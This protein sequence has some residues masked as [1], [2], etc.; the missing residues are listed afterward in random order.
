M[1]YTIQYIY[2]KLL[3]FL[4]NMGFDVRKIVA[5][6][7]YFKYRA[8]KKEFRQRGGVITHRHVI[9]E[10]FNDQAGSARGHY[11]HQDLLVASLIFKKNPSRHVDVGLA[12]M[13]L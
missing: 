1:K 4:F 3:F 5:W 8:H 2:R 10:D 12:W 11:F 9:L 7:H 6:R 13:D